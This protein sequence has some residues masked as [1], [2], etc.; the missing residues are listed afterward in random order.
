MSELRQRFHQVVG[1]QGLKDRL[2]KF[3]D[4]TATPEEMPVQT[5]ESIA[6]LNISGFELLVFM[7][8]SDSDNSDSKLG[9]PVIQILLGGNFI[10]KV[11]LPQIPRNFLYQI[12]FKY[13]DPISQQPLFWEPLFNKKGFVEFNT[14]AKGQQIQGREENVTGVKGNEGLPATALST[15]GNFLD[16]SF[17]PKTLG[18]RRRKTR[19]R[20]R[21][22]KRKTR[23]H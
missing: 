16:A 1:K 11:R 5:S 22:H 9:H 2:R 10:A 4:G 17:D 12:E 23:K 15:I 14:F 18:G 19:S 7:P 20:S 3:F 13:Y 8:T 6:Q 21:K